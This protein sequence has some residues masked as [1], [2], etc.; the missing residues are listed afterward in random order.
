MSENSCQLC[1]VEK[2]TFEPP[3]MYC[4][5]CGARIK[6]N[7]MYYT[8]GAGDTRHYFCIPCYNEARGDT[9]IV[10]GT[11][12]PK[13]RLEKKKNDEETEEWVCVICWNFSCSF[14]IFLVLY[15]DSSRQS[16]LCFSILIII[17]VGSM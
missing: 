6:R 3:P 8:M 13:A 1:A 16:F 9:I 11:A 14:S 12:I 10:D 15:F 2:L 5:P 17:T 7:S 4:T